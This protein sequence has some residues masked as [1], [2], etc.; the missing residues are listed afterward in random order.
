MCLRKWGL[1]ALPV[2]VLIVMLWS[3]AHPALAADDPRPATGFIKKGGVRFYVVEKR[4]EIDGR[5]GL[6]RWLIELLACEVGG[7]EHKSVIALDVKPEILYFCLLLMKLERGN[8]APQRPAAPQPAPSSV[9]IK[10]RW[11]DK[12][13]VEKTVPA[14]DLCWDAA[15][16]RPMTP[17]SWRFVRPQFQQQ[18]AN[19]PPGWE[20]SIIGLQDPSAML[21]PAVP[22]D[23]ATGAFTINERLAPPVGTPCTIILQPVPE[24]IPAVQPAEP[25]AK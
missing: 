15:A 12:Q 16:K 11:A 20:K 24:V 14:E 5:F 17:T 2:S 1:G 19:A 18:P 21:Q 6:Q 25:K 23:M 3:G 7:K 10:V 13:G 8:P 22:P 9:V 4:I